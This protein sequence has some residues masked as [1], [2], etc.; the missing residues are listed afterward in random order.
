MPTGGFWTPWL[1]FALPQCWPF[2]WWIAVVLDH[3]SRRVMGIAVFR[4]QPDGRQ[5]REFLD[6]AI[7]TAGAKPKYIVCDKGAQFWCLPFKRWCRRRKIRPRFGAIGRHG[8]IA[9]VERFTLS[10]KEEF[11]R[12]IIVPLNRRRSDEACGL[13]SDW[14]NRFRPH[15]FLGGR[16]PEGRYRRIPAAC[17]RL[18]FEP[19]L[20]WP[21][22]SP[23][24]SPQ[25]KVRASPGA[26]L[27]LHVERIGG[28]RRLPVV[29]ITRAA[30][31]TRNSAPNK[32]ASGTRGIP[33][34][35][36]PT[37]INTGQK[38]PA[39]R[40][41]CQTASRDAS[42]RRDNYRTSATRRSLVRHTGPGQHS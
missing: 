23:C 37:C 39:P 15:E 28:H 24:A 41:C 32:R 5:V 17:R 8:S 30:Q 12:C 33:K 1:P 34:L 31:P 6:S 2:C 3:F 25:A 19:R 29:T 4:K 38:V 14:Y 9:V 26:K 20:H 40:S 22:G 36:T 11:L 7:R 13:Y 21:R 18:R 10:M 16:T 27:E 35:P 42:S